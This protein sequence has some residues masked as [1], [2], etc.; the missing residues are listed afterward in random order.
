V[1]GWQSLSN[2]GWG[3]RRPKKEV[4]GG[5]REPENDSPARGDTAGVGVC[6]EIDNG[7]GQ[8]CDGGRWLRRTGSAWKSGITTDE[9]WMV[10]GTVGRRR[11]RSLLMDRV[12]G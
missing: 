8:P 5:T 9:R 3:G 7:I 4:D 1:D 12:G 10:V 11:G 2:R 6:R